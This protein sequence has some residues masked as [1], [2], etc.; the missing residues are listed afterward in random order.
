[1]DRGLYIAASGMLTEL[2]RQDQLANDLA[3]ASTP[4]YKADRSAQSSFEDVLLV[5][6]RTGEPIGSLPFG[7]AISE[8]RTDLSQGPMK[9]TGE[10]L[11]VALDG[12][13]F[14]AVK[15]PTGVRYTRDGQFDVDAKGQLVSAT[16]YPVLDDKGS[17]IVIQ[18]EGN[19]A[20][21]PDGAVTIGGK[22]VATLAVVSL[23]GPHKE[24]DTLFTG[25]PGK[26]PEG[27][28]VRQGYLEA[29]AVNVAEAM[30]DMIGSMR[31]YESVQ[32][33]IHA[34]DETLGR[35]IN[36]VTQ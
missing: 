6:E 4:G 24:G 18:G 34:I 20:I 12:D 2:A 5:N 30:V 19:P 16:G 9:E 8:V 26:R 13:G 3:N 31:A 29:S 23:D 1:M 35:G 36:G 33:V 28:S 32:R 10:P 11:D 22:P 17:A 21:G 27:T 14:F 15:T 25:K 7:T